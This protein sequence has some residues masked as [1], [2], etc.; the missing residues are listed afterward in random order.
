MG[1]ILL[2]GLIILLYVSQCSEY[3]LNDEW[4][5]WCWN[6]GGKPPIFYGYVKLPITITLNNT[7]S[8]W[9]GN[10]SQQGLLT[11]CSKS[12]PLRCDVELDRNI[13]DLYLTVRYRIN[14]VTGNVVHVG[15]ALY[16]ELDNNYLA[17]DL[18]LYASDIKDT[19][20]WYNSSI[21]P[22]YHAQYVLVKSNIGRWY[23]E[24]LDVSRYV[25][26][27]LNHFGYDGGKLAALQ[28]YIDG[29]SCYGEVEFNDVKLIYKPN[30]TSTINSNVVLLV[31]LIILL[32]IIILSIIIKVSST[33][34]NKA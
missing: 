5:L 17:I 13:R 9:M 20:Y 23:N 29:V 28:L 6:H 1:G 19:N 33:H 16:I 11:Y 12:P 7:Y 18:L 10:V 4:G 8:Y 22:D 14:N 3:V 34:K 15:V 30:K 21:D 27:A 25:V 31:I 24:S 26:E 2:V 32:T